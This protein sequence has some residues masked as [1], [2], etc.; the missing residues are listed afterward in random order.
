[1]IIYLHKQNDEIGT[2]IYNVSKICTFIII[3]LIR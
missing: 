3:E 1:M 2:R